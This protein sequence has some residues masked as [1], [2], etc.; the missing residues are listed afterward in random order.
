[1]VL[2]GTGRNFGAGMSGGIA[3]VWDPD[4]SFAG[5]L[6]AEMVDLDALDDEDVDWLHGMIVA[7]VDAT[8]S[9]VGQRILSDWD[10]ALK[11]FVKV[12]PRDFKRV[13]VAIAEAEQ[14]GADQNE[15]AKAIMA[16]AN[17]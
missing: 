8:D 5:N 13:L 17:A 3:Y 4:R 1:V 9:A 16:A 11:H 2:G 10:G 7:H 12:M 14:R 6:N 15:V